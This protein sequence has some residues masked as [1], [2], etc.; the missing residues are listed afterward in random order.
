MK[1]FMLHFILLLISHSAKAHFQVLLPSSDIVNDPQMITLTILFTYPMEQGPLM[2]MDLP[3]QFGVM[4]QSKK[5]NLLQ[6]LQAKKQEGKT[7]FTSEYRFDA[8]ADYLF[9]IEPAPY[10]EASEGK[11]IIHYTKVIVDVLDAQEG[12]NHLV[13]FPVEIEPLVRPYGL[14]VGN[15]FQGIVKKGGHAVP[16][17]TVEVEYFN[18]GHRVAIPSPAFTAQVIHADAQGIFTYA[19][20][21]AGW[22]GFAALLEG[23][24]PLKN[25]EGKE[26][27]VELGA[28]I[29][30]HTVEMK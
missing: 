1:K 7:F 19:M 26:V 5:K 25:P 17:A 20:P 16:F 13:G 6:T 22:W 10:W 23:D 15:I 14:W 2:N 3:K 28:L 18:E 27:P 12:W 29:W 8:P 24:Q 11:M 21:K 4:V 9:F 30:I